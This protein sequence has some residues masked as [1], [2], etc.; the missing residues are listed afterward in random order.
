[1]FILVSDIKGQEKLVFTYFRGSR[2][3]SKREFCNSRDKQELMGLGGGLYAAGGDEDYEDL[4]AKRIQWLL[5][6]CALAPQE[7]L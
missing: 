3:C 1:M 6:G 7:S 4:G 2:L 5:H